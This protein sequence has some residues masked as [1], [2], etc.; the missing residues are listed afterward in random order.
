MKALAFK[1]RARRIVDAA[2]T[3]ALFVT[4]CG[5]AL[6][7]QAN[8]K[9]RAES[10]SGKRGME[11]RKADVKALPSSSKRWALIIGI[12][13]YEDPDIN[14][15]N[16]AVKDAKTLRLAL[17]EHCKFPD[18]NVILLTSDSRD[19]DLRPTKSN[20]IDKLSGLKREVQPDG[21]LL[22]AFS[23]HGID[24]DG[25]AF[26]LPMES[27]LSTDPLRLTDDAVS[28]ER[29]KEYVNRT[30]VRQRIMFLDACRNK[31]SASKGIDVSPLSA[32]YEKA[33]EFDFERRNSK[34]DAFLTFYAT[35]KGQESWEDQETGQGY[36]T[37]AIVDALHGGA[38]GEIVNSQGEVTL[39]ALTKYVRESVTNRAAKA[40]KTQVPHPVTDGYGDDLVLAKVEV[41]PAAEARV[42]AAAPAGPP[43]AAD[44]EA[45]SEITYW[46]GIVNRTN[47]ELF[48]NYLDDFPT[49]RFVKPAKT[50]LADLE[51]GYWRSVANSRE[52]QGLRKYLE[53]Y[54]DGQFAKAAKGSL[55]RLDNAR[56]KLIGATSSQ[57]ELQGYLK[58]YPD[59]QHVEA[60]NNRL[61]RL[62]N[63][64]KPETLVVRT[65]AAT[66]SPSPESTAATPA[67]VTPA[68][69][70][71]KPAAGSAT[72]T[73]PTGTPAAS[74]S[75]TSS[76]A[77]NT[78]GTNK[79]GTNTPGTNTPGSTAPPAGT[80]PP[81]EAGAFT[82]K[83]RGT[84]VSGR[85][86]RAEGLRPTLPLQSFAFT[87]RKLKR[88]ASGHDVIE[89]RRAAYYAED[90]GGG[91]TLRMVELPR[92]SFLMGD[93]ASV[94]ERP[95]HPVTIKSFFMGEFEVTQ[96][97]WR[98]V[99]KLP[100]VRIDINPDPSYFK[101]DDLPV[102]NVSW[103]EAVEFC[104]RLSRKTG[105]TYRLPSEAEWE[106]ACRA[107]SLTQFAFGDN[108]SAEFIN[109]DGQHP[110]KDGP[111]GER[112]SRPISTGSLGVANSFGLYD[113]HGNALEWCS[114]IWHD[115]YDNAPADGRSWDAGPDNSRV[116]RGGD[117]TLPA[118][119]ARS[120]ARTRKIGRAHV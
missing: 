13:K 103:D 119:R 45:A 99:A 60:A 92:G 50:F 9:N 89:E 51:K 29:V 39:G 18:E 79:P 83:E 112:R 22:F 8:K 33:F 62:E 54:P 65:R 35:E 5:P 94:T 70:T 61:N 59:G 82:D 4:I 34:I 2:L 15:L 44:P 113:M 76:V 49:G 66:T 26:L 24:V 81:S 1:V 16:G 56:W 58:D 91:V 32:A 10:R 52:P 78:P 95:Q 110:Y 7:G 97:Q 108:I 46:N 21:L 17:T 84:D 31:L 69:S 63:K 104:E 109:F 38:R 87:T 36:F 53:I 47:P 28:V 75:G 102:G 57:E 120:S 41:K 37:E 40:G 73:P 107:G 74:A 116:L 3:A 111:A 48:K 42:A 106:Y 27:K 71:N 98:A 6:Y 88:S 72:A 96:Q 117:W 114:D 118:G 43:S 93:S 23:G 85:P 12:D 68:P 20:I 90:I 80:T 14:S 105:R 100:K 19:K 101:G 55:K 77:T 11:V 25:Q 30:G 115:S 64:G 86:G 67:P